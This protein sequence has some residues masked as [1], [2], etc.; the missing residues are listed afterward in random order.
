MPEWRFDI[1][2]VAA[3][4]PRVGKWG[5]Y[6]TG[7]YKAFREEAAAKVWEILGTDLEPLSGPL[8]VSIELF[9]KRPKT[10]E[11]DWPKADIDNFAKAVL[12]TMNKK[13]W[14]DD[15]QIISLYV[16]KQW[17]AKD[18]GGYFILSVNNKEVED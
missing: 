16:T 9:V 15:S 14:D 18:E 17:A 3:S 2:P 7:T 11:R 13:V 10:T 4:R 1:N 12:D 8:M 5:A 6:Y